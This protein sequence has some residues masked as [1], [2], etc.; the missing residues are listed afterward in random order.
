[1]QVVERLTDV[2]AA[3]IIYAGVSGKYIALPCTELYV[4][5]AL[6][7]IYIESS[8]PRHHRLS[9]SNR[10]IGRDRRPGNEHL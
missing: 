2:L 7:S 6:D 10:T 4:V 5:V 8:S 3:G 9:K 1:M